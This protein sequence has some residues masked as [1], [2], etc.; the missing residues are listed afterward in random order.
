[1]D[2]AVGS[3]TREDMQRLLDAQREAFMKA[4]APSVEQRLESL[5]KLQRILVDNQEAFAD[6]INADFG[7]RS[8]LETLQA[9]IFVTVEAIKH[10]RKHLRGWMKPERRPINRLLFGLAK[11]RVHYQPLGVVGIIAPWNYPVQLALD[12]LAAAL[13]AGNR[14]MVKPS[15]YTPRTAALMRELIAR[16]FD[17]TEVA[18]VTGGP[19]TGQ[20]FSTLRFDHLLY[21]GST[22][23]GRLVMMAAAENMVPVTLELGGKSP[24]ILGEDYPVKK[25]VDSIVGGKWYNA[26]QTCIAPDYTFVPDAQ[27]S[28][29]VEN[30]HRK[31]TEAYPSLGD[32]PEYTSIVHERHYDR[33]RGLLDDAKAK[34]AE[35]I[36]INPK[37]EHLENHRKIAPT[38]LLNVNEDM[39]VM[40]EEI[41]GPLLPIM[42]YK[43]EQEAIDYVNAH[44]RPLALYY[45]SGSARKQQRMIESTTSGGVAINETLYH[46]VQE[47]LPFGG[48]GPSGTGAY[49]GWYGFETFSHRKGTFYQA[50]FNSAEML[51]PPVKP[52]AIRMLK[53]MI[54]K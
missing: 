9:E 43:D 27:L 45:F 6:A 12:P 2:V 23:V 46:V 19:E 35:V 36:E 40:Q 34:G 16:D 21:T 50:R 11:A 25:A 30:M 17:E 20:A 33:L 22:K 48:V 47:E 28:G 53:T 18:I 49:H 29:F 1:M 8:R 4:G 41:F 14:A 32:N 37:G 15:E 51:R 13:A 54:G 7:T 42:T 31:V 39:E 26:G 38:L 44:E 3:A 10:A 24:T 5:E 52:Y